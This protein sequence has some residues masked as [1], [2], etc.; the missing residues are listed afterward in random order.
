MKSKYSL[1]LILASLTM[2]MINSTVFAKTLPNTI[3][4]PVNINITKPTETFYA[5]PNGLVTIEATATNNVSNPYAYWGDSYVGIVS[6]GTLSFASG[7]TYRLNWYP[8]AENRGYGS[9]SFTTLKVEADGQSDYSYDTRSLYITQANKS[10]YDSSSTSTW[11][12]V[13]KASQ[14]NNCL[15]YVLGSYN[16]IIWYWSVYNPTLSEVV[17]EMY[18]RRWIQVYS[19]NEAQI[20]AYGSGNN[21]THFA[22]KTGTNTIESKWGSYEA[23]RNNCIGTF[24]AFLTAD[25][26]KPLAYFKFQ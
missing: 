21:V 3:I 9:R 4:Y 22:R 26:G 16:S 18:T 15:A 2:L 11:A 19:A 5:P 7:N 24:D 8:S 13:A 25:Y 12:I 17:R 1:M 6:I 14:T 10:Y 20:I 23:V